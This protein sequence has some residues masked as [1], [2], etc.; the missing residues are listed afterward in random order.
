MPPGK[1]TPVP[2]DSGRAI[3]LSADLA[4]GIQSLSVFTPDF[5]GFDRNSDGALNDGEAVLS[6][7]AQHKDEPHTLRAYK[8]ALAKF[9]SFWQDKPLCDFKRPH[10]VAFVAFLEGNELSDASID[11][12]VA[13]CSSLFRHL[14][15]GGY[16]R[17]NPFKGYKRRRRTSKLMNQRF[18]P[19][20][21]FEHLEE[22]MRLRGDEYPRL[23]WWLVGITHL[24]LRRAEAA[25]LTSDKLHR[26]YDGDW[27]L[28]IYGKGGYED[29]IPVHPEAMSSYRAFRI[30]LGLPELPITGE[31][32]A[33]FP[34]KR[35]KPIKAGTIY[36]HLKDI[37]ASA[38]EV[39]RAKGDES[40]AAI[41]DKASPHWLRHTELS[42]QARKLSLPMVGEFGRHRRLDTTTQYVHM[43]R[44]E[45]HRQVSKT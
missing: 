21:A 1:E 41:L 33:L 6:W 14:H 3:I 8:G 26:D 22:A 5:E 45:W 36:G 35:N 31:V 25:L 30:S 20:V 9:L 42:R 4:Q 15:D 24:A 10:S 11:H 43:E 18:L 39:A 32:T 2:A 23:R 34:G 29:D 38:A 13:S 19:E 44:K 40:T 7:L 16:L 17:F 27:W 12:C 37:F 28:T